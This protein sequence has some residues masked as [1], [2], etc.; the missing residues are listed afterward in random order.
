MKIFIFCG[1]LLAPL[2][3]NAQDQWSDRIEF[4]EFGAFIHSIS[5]PFKSS[6]G[7]L[8]LNRWP[9]FRLSSSFTLKKGQAASSYRPSLS[10]YHQSNLH[11]GLHFNQQFALSSPRGKALAAE[12]LLGPGYLHT[13]EDAPLYHT[14]KGKVAR[15]RD[16]GRAQFTVSLAFGLGFR[17]NRAP[18]L[19]TFIQQE[20]LLQ[21]PFAPKGGVNFIIHNRTHL[22]LRR[23]F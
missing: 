10:F 2:I 15:K 4:V 18:N 12:L 11:Y 6:N 17:W 16:W 1:F 9:G 21:F 23:Y 3:L 14:K 19:M 13:F 8:K 20:L 5:L 22:S 7:F